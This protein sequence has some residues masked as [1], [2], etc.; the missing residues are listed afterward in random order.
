[1]VIKPETVILRHKHGFRAYLRWK[2][3][4]VVGRLKIDRAILDLFKRMNKENRR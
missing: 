2:S 1:M 4:R 3:S